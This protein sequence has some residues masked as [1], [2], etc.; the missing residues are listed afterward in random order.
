LS[1]TSRSTRRSSSA[2]TNRLISCWPRASSARSAEPR[3]TPVDVLLRQEVVDEDLPGFSEA[4]VKAILRK[5]RDNPEIGKPLGGKLRGCR[6][7]RLEGEN[8]VVYRVVDVSGE[9][10]SR[11]SRSTDV[12]PVPPTPLPRNVLDLEAEDVAGPRVVLVS[13]RPVLASHFGQQPG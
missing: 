2:S 8:R 1:R 12:E 10:L 5:I 6:S 7:V 9:T 4:A 11:S 13:R 3:S